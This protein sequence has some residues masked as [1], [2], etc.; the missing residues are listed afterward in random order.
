[1]LR[2]SASREGVGLTGRAKTDDAPLDKGKGKSTAP[3][4][5][6]EEEEEE[7]SDDELIVRGPRRR[8]QVDYASVST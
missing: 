2:R 3:P 1:M 7:D 5:D 8:R 4:E 6:E